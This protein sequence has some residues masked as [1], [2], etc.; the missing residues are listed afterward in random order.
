LPSNAQAVVF[1]DDLGSIAFRHKSDYS[2]VRRL[3]IP[4]ILRMYGKAEYLSSKVLN[5][6]QSI[7]NEFLHLQV[8]AAERAVEPTGCS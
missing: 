4:T 8:V 5:C 1:I 3:I 7:S 6:S 2:T